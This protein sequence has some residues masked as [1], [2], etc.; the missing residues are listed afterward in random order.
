MQIFCMKLPSIGGDLMQIFCM[1]LPLYI[2]YNYYVQ[3][4]SIITSLAFGF[5]H[6]KI[7]NNKI[8][9]T[10]AILN[11]TVE[12][13]IKIL[14]KILFI[15]IITKITYYIQ[16]IIAYIIIIIKIFLL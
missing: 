11:F 8:I 13:F 2:I 16:R 4:I 14:F 6:N 10:T 1:R 15:K 3:N 9:K 5:L 7:I 12:L